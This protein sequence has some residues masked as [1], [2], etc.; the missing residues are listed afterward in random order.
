MPI[1]SVSIVLDYGYSLIGTKLA[2][3]SPIKRRGHEPVSAGIHDP[4]VTE[5]SKSGKPEQ[6]KRNSNECSAAGYFPCKSA[7]CT[8]LAAH[9]QRHCGRLHKRR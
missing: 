1:N 2:T 5:E 4:H 9:V 3:K 7:C 8:N 6:P